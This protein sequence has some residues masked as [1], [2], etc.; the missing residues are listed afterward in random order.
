[1]LSR[2]EVYSLAFLSLTTVGTRAYWSL[3]G[4]TCFTEELLASRWGPLEWDAEQR[5]C[6][7]VSLQFHVN[8]ITPRRNLRRL[9]SLEASYH[10]ALHLL[11][12][13]LT[14]CD[15]HEHPWRVW[16]LPSKANCTLDNA[17]LLCSSCIRYC[18]SF[19]F[20]KTGKSAIS[21]DCPPLHHLVASL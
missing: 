18:F 16:G 9:R 17:R 10:L 13:L 3:Y 5:M 2:S 8:V 1:M 20:L 11:T 12:A 15:F 7:V 21:F 19:V 4:W 14:L 6:S